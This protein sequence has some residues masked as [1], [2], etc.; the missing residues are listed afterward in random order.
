MVG[1][2]MGLLFD[3]NGV[4]IGL[5]VMIIVINVLFDGKGGYMFID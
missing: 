4:Y 3:N 1:M 5:G 2:V